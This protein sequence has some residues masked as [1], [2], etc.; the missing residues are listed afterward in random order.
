MDSRAVLNTT[1][2][3]DNAAPIL[4]NLPSVS[5]V[6]ASLTANTALAANAS[7]TT[8]A[9]IATPITPILPDGA[10]L[11][12]VITPNVPAS[13]ASAST[14]P[15]GATASQDHPSVVTIPDN[16]AGVSGAAVT[17]IAASDKPQSPDLSSVRIPPV[18]SA[19]TSLNRNAGSPITA[20][21]ETLDVRSVTQAPSTPEP[22]NAPATS[23]GKQNLGSI[24]R[25]LT[26][27]NARTAPPV[28]QA[29]NNIIEPKSEPLTG[30]PQDAPFLSPGLVAANTVTV[31]QGVPA[32]VNTLPL[33]TPVSTPVTVAAQ[34]NAPVVLASS[35]FGRAG[36]IGVAAQAL[37]G[38]PGVPELNHPGASSAAN[39]VGGIGAVGE[40]GFLPF[41]Q[42][43]TL[44][45]SGFEEQGQEGA[46]SS[47]NEQ[48]A[49]S[50][51][52]STNTVG[53]GAASPFAV[54]RTAENV[55]AAAQ[56]ASTTNSSQIERAHVVEQVTR[57]LESMRLTSAGGEMRLRL[58]PQNLGS[59]QV[60]VTA[61]Q[62]GVLAR[63]AVETAQ[64][65]QAMEGAKEHLRAGLEAR[66]LR[67]QS[68][69]VAVVPNVLSDN[70]A[71]F[72]GQRNWQQ[73]SLQD[74]APGQPGYGRRTAPSAEPVPN[75]A[76]IA[77]RPRASLSDSRLDCRA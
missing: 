6:N 3:I 8:D 10:N 28:V 38:L 36:K 76:P 77:V 45:D 55:P 46:Q 25:L 66:G 58:N 15:V 52:Q 49:S 11:N 42:A 68:V 20:P 57:H 5:A 31:R 74:S 39:T 60:T 14:A 47:P 54:P 21:A 12:N 4:S 53:P 64:V 16:T 24:E 67:V 63:I 70:T 44:A 13:V 35:D 73:A 26:L 33:G 41:A 40:S 69:E 7:L 29:V 71:A 17:P 1:P 56:A 48:E 75:V 51:I 9:N 34:P 32:G 62:D 37:H 30:A 50:E 27:S 22:E 65:Q 19:A 72:S 23:S 61:H 2:G 43:A 18:A 59:V